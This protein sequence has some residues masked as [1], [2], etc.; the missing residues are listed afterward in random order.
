MRVSKWLFYAFWIFVIG[1]CNVDSIEKVVEFS[2]EREQI[3]QDEVAELDVTILDT[4]I[5]IHKYSA[6]NFFSVYSKESWQFLR[7]WLKNGNGPNE[8]SAP[9]L[10]RQIGSEKLFV[11]DVFKG[12]VFQLKPNSADLSIDYLSDLDPAI[13]LTQDMVFK[14]DSIIIG[15]LGYLSP[16]PYLLKGFDF[17]NQKDLFI[18][19]NSELEQYEAQGISDFYTTF[20]N[21]FRMKPDGHKSVMAFN[22]FDRL[23]IFDKDFNV[24]NEVVG[25]SGVKSLK[26]VDGEPVDLINYYFDLEVTEDYIFGLFYD[27]P[28]SEY[29]DKMQ[30]SQIKVFDWDGVLLKVIEVP[31]YLMGISFDEE[32]QVLYGVDHFQEKILKYDFSGYLD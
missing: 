31:D 30:P 20:Y 22:Y 25:E 24:T 13:G 32:N 16:D 3:L 14:N 17:K 21:F 18:I 12:G 8:F 23:L 10:I 1:S 9:K 27:Q 11:Y 7:D 5:L 6:K 4:L 19:Q 28:E 29:G 15:N 2:G 26:I